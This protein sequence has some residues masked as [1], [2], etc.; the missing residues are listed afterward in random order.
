MPFIEVGGL[1]AFYAIM[2]LCLCYVFSPEV[3]DL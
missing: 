3:C 1:S 2:H